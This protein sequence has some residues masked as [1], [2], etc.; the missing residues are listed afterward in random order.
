MAKVVFCGNTDFSIEAVKPL[1]G[2]FDL[3]C[4]SKPYSVFSRWAENC[5]LR[6]V[7]VKSLKREI[8]K[9]VSV[10]ET[11]ELLVSCDFGL[12]IPREL[13]ELPSV[14]SVNIHP[15]LLPKYR[16]PAPIQHAI[17]NGD[18]ETGLTYIQI[19]EELDAGGIYF[20]RK[21]MITNEDTYTDLRKKLSILV[22]ETIYLVLTNILE[23][24]IT[25]IPQDPN[26]VTWAP[27]ISENDEKLRITTCFRTLRHINALSYSPGAYVIFRNK[28]LKILKAKI[29]DAPSISNSIFFEKNKLFL[30]C[31]DGSLEILECQ[32]EGGKI[33]SGLDFL[34]G[35]KKS[36]PY[37]IYDCAS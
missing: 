31:D 32:L 21:I 1:L 13:F 24:K 9:V 20:S 5:G 12:I 37:R 11:C 18:F 16:G 28:R 2:R 14:A 35:F 8:D 7:T 4:I 29:S 36:L 6:I 15:S 23:G 25:I 22:S 3:V 19:C 30:G 33:I 17:L 10:I 26:Q 27:K 34:N